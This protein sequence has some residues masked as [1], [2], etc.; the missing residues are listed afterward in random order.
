[1]KKSNQSQNLLEKKEGLSRAQMK[2]IIGGVVPPPPPE[3]GE[4]G[5]GYYFLCQ[6][7]NNGKSFSADSFAG[8]AMMLHDVC[9][10]GDAPTVCATVAC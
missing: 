10:V 1:M 4:P 8:Y 2:S 7:L 5:N 6:C 9:G 3:M